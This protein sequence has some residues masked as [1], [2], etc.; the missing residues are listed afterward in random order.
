MARAAGIVRRMSRCARITIAICL[1][2]VTACTNIGV[3]AAKR[4]RLFEALQSSAPQS[5]ALSPRSMQ[6]LRLY[7]L[8]R[9]YDRNP[10]EAAVQLRDQSIREP[11]VDAIFALCEIH[12]LRGQA[13]EKKRPAQ[14]IEH[15]YC[16][17]GYAQH[18]LLAS[19][20]VE[21]KA[22]APPAECATSLSPR[23]AF[24][25]RFRVACELYND[26]LCRCLRASQKLGLLDARKELR[27][28]RGETTESLP[29][30]QSGFAWKPDDFGALY[31]SSDYE[32]VGLPNQYHD[33]GLGVPL[34]A[35]LSKNAAAQNGY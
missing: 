10:D 25:P 34:I 17:C 27:L 6:T 18:Y 31:V 28:P 30:I 1:L 16:A 24:V 12:Y 22:N 11:N 23:D 2:S 3:R 9:M 15:F 20:D 21:P 32:V 29:V 7:D 5:A 13:S 4:P 14:A 35:T 8:D 33:Y 19:C 26:G